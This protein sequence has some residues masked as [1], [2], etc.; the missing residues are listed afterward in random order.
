MQAAILD[1]V[2]LMQRVAD[3]DADA[4]RSLYERYGR[5]VYS[6]A[7]RHTR[8]AGMAE[9]CTQDAFLVLWRRAST[10]DP[11]RA[12]LT[13]WLLTITR[14]R[15]IELVRQ[16]SRRP[17]PVS[18]VS[19]AG[20]APDPSAVAVESDQSQRVAEA[21]AELPPEQRE[22]VSLAYFDGLSHTEIAELIG[23]PLGTV[24]G[25]MRLALSRLRALV[26]QYDLHPEQR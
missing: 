11:A 5:I 14:N 9:E 13:T 23:A 1:D 8:D 17:D 3:G 4:L 10:F 21:L 6:F 7:L 15:A 19:L 26:D 25:R 22:V 16:R 20:S 18:E 24:K 2:Q 12:K